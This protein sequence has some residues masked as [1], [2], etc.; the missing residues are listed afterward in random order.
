MNDPL[1]VLT[2]AEVD[3][4]QLS[5]WRLA[6][7]ELMASFRTDTFGIGR[8]FVNAIAATAET[9]DHHPHLALDHDSVEVRLTSHDA[10]GVT[11]RDVELARLISLLAKAAQVS[12]DA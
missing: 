12:S 3:A 1:P 8:S 7:T 9:L 2:A 10:G 11:A 4:A 5:D 6:D